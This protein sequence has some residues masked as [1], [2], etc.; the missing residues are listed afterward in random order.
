[1]T[2]GILV[3]FAENTTERWSFDKKAYSSLADNDSGDRYLFHGSAQ[4]DAGPKYNPEIFTGEEAKIKKGSKLKMSLYNIV[5]TSYADE[6][7]EFFAQITSDVTTDKGVIIPA[8]SF[9]HGTIDQLE[10]AKKLRRDGHVNLIFD[11]I[12]TPDGRKIP[13]NATM[14]TKANT[15]KAVAKHVAKDA[16]Y[17]LGGG[18]IGGWMALNMLG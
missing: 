17:M 14:T 13:I 2:G 16:G 9:A 15:A 4:L 6:N 1:M 10:R 12:A 11:Y 8:G 5:S 18:A 3:S 7:D